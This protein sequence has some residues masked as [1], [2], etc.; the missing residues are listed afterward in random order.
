MS[1]LSH[2]T[3]KPTLRR[4]WVLLAIAF[5]LSCNGCPS[6]SSTA[7]RGTPSHDAGVSSA[8]DDFI[9]ED[10]YEILPI[11][12]RTKPADGVTDYANQYS[13][14]VMVHATLETRGRSSCSGALLSP[15]LVLTAA[16]CV[17]A[18]LEA[19]SPDSE[20]HSIINGA[21]CAASVTAETITYTGRVVESQVIWNTRGRESSGKV[22]PHPAFEILLDK[23]GLP[24]SIKA[25]LAVIELDEPIQ[26]TSPAVHLPA[27][28]I[29]PDETF[30]IVGHGHDGNND[31]IIGGRRLG[32][33][34]VVGAQPS[35]SDGVTFAQVGASFTS[36]S[37]DACLRQG[38]TRTELIGITT[39]PL[40]DGFA[41]TSLYPYRDWL[42]AELRQAATRAQSHAIPQE[43]TP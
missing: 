12:H 28:E 15:Y 23:R 20:V 39:Q 42:L 10:E 18:A 6:S 35:R 4:A 21:S 22:R 7:A 27:S 2:V 1:E 13:F 31:L 16:H 41:F 24:L 11:G 19:P 17:C 26:G 3:A 14:A 36:G 29:K 8:D 40:E 32:R 38:K 30:T 33:K 9:T 25:D 5:L 34:K 43:P 37:G